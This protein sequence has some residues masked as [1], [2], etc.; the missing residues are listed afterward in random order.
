MKHF[1]MIKF[2]DTFYSQN[3]IQCIQHELSPPMRSLNTINSEPTTEVDSAHTT[4]TQV[5]WACT[6]SIYRLKM[7]M[8]RTPVPSCCCLMVK[9]P[10]DE[11]VLLWTFCRCSITKNKHKSGPHSEN[12]SRS[13]KQ[14]HDG[15]DSIFVKLVELPRSHRTSLWFI[16]S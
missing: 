14:V 16:I 9:F 8:N 12:D 7:K 10:V 5:P 13:N 11:C 2:H 3:Y 4:L 1:R 15:K 6:S